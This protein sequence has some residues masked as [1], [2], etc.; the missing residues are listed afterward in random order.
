MS[1]EPN[2][3]VNPAYRH[4]YMTYVYE[5]VYICTNK[6]IYIIHMTYMYIYI[7]HMY[8]YNTYVHICEYTYVRLLGRN[9]YRHTYIYEHVYM[10]MHG[11]NIQI[12][13][14][15]MSMHGQLTQ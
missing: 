14:Y 12:C 5:H 13:A 15:A 3:A 1:H 9:M 4:M 11:T 2:D 6:Y 7:I 8:I 10:S